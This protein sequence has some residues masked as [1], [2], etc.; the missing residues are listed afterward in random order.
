M[1]VDFFGTI[2]QPSVNLTPA[3]APSKRAKIWRWP[4]ETGQPT[5]PG[6]KGTLVC[7]PAASASLVHDLAHGLA[8]QVDRGRAEGVEAEGEGG[9]VGE[10]A[11]GRLLEGGP[12]AADGEHH[13]PGGMQVLGD[14]GAREMAGAYSQALV[15]EL[16]RP[17][18]VS[19]TTTGARRGRPVATACSATL[20]AGER[21]RRTTSGSA[22]RVRSTMSSI[23][24]KRPVGDESQ[25]ASTSFTS[26]TALQASSA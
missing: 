25:A 2:M 20:T 4:L 24:A 3:R 13:G 23:G 19:V 16:V 22:P 17:R 12:D 6:L 26:R 9:V 11:G 1:E 7:S 21:R 15:A 14:E 18:S 8:Q 5:S 10:Q